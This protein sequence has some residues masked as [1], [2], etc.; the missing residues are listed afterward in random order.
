MAGH[1][2]FRN[3]GFFYYLYL[4]P[5]SCTEVLIEDNW[6]GGKRWGGGAGGLRQPRAGQQGGKRRIG[7]AL[8]FFGNFYMAVQCRGT[9]SHNFGY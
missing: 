6:G 9:P 3:I 8:I 2:V 7:T 1:S 4:V 5:D